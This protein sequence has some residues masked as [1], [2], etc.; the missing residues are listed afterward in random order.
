M[1][2]LKRPSPGLLMLLAAC[3]TDATTTATTGVVRVDGALDDGTGL[4]D[5]QTGTATPAIVMGPQGGQHVWTVVTT[6][7]AFYAKRMRITVEMTDLDTG[8]IVKPGAFQFTKD[9]VDTA[10]GLQSPAITAFVKE[11]CKVKGHHLRVRAD[12]E[13]LV[14]VTGSAEATITP[15]WTGYCAP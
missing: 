11:P 3:A 6:S 2:T 4:V 7:H 14:G 9:M 1:W 10:D 15:T 13:D 12:V 5:W 8:E